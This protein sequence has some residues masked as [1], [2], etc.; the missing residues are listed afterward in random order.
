ML[1]HRRRPWVRN[2]RSSPVYLYFSMPW[3]LRDAIAK[4]SAKDHQRFS[5]G[6][7]EDSAMTPS[8]G[9]Y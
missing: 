5:V 1:L 3:Y 4:I 7:W 6:F 9:Q 2:P 8:G